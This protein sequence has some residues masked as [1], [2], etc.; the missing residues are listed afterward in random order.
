MT[1]R[2]LVIML[3]Q[4]I[5]GCAGIGGAAYGIAWMI[6]TYPDD[7]LTFGVVGVVGFV[8][9]VFVYYGIDALDH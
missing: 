4:V 9:C 1:K 2:E 5:V 8:F 7:V 3:I 6:A